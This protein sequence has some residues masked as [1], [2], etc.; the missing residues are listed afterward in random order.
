MSHGRKPDQ[1]CGGGTNSRPGHCLA[2]S[3]KEITMASKGPTTAPPSPKS[4]GKHGGNRG[5]DR[6]RAADKPKRSSQAAGKE[7]HR[8]KNT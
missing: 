7:P 1:R 8:G 6:T 4:R 2:K 5:G 3:E